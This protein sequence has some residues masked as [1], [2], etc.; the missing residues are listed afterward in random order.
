MSIQFSA[1]RFRE[2]RSVNLAVPVLALALLTLFGTA[3]EKTLASMVSDVSP[4]VVQ[5]VTPFRTGS[6]FIVDE[7]GLVITNAHVVQRFETVDVRLASGQQ[8]HAEVLR[9]DEI[10]DLAL[11]DLRA[12]RDFR[13]VPLGDS[14][15]VMVGEDVIAIGFPSGNTEVLHDSPTITKGI[16]S[17]KRVSGS[18][19]RLLQTDAAINPGTSGGPLFDHE[20]RVV[21]VN[22]L[23]IFESGDGRPVE[24]IGLVVAISEVKDRMGSLEKASLSD[25]FISVSAGQFHTCGLKTDRSVVCWG[26][27]PSSPVGTFDS[28]ST[29]TGGN[30]YSCGVTTDGSVMCWGT[31]ESEFTLSVGSYTSVS[32]GGEHECGVKTD[33]SVE[34]WGT[35]DHGQSTP[36]AGSFTS[37]SAGYQSTCGVKTDS[38]IVC[39]GSNDD[40]RSTPPSGSFAS[41][42]AGWGH[43]C[44]VKTDRSV[45]CWGS[46]DHGESTPPSGSFVSVSAGGDHTCG[47]K[48]DRSVVCWGNDFMGQSSADSRLTLLTSMITGRYNDHRTQATVPGPFASVSAGFWYTCAVKT[49]GAVIC[50][51]DNSAGQ[52]TPPTVRVNM[53]DLALLAVVSA[54]SFCAVALLLTDVEL[55]GAKR[56][57]W[58]V[59]PLTPIICVSVW[60]SNTFFPVAVVLTGA[61]LAI[62]LMGWRLF[63]MKPHLTIR[64]VLGIFLASL[65]IAATLATWGTFSD[66]AID[67]GRGAFY[68]WGTLAG[69]SALATVIVPL[70]RPGLRRAL[71]ATVAFVLMFVFFEVIFLL[72]V[73]NVFSYGGA[74]L[75][76]FVLVAVGAV[77]TATYFGRTGRQLRSDDGTS[78]SGPVSECRTDS[79]PG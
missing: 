32:A 60:T 58:G 64:R 6:G 31:I 49:D 41:V 5:I 76:T 16:V 29:A 9:V 52:A 21:G 70:T 59:I 57:A 13:A 7:D 10:A 48:T 62:M 53:V 11:L 22:T 67:W 35:D 30:S 63:D 73:H 33:G 38:S 79:T 36:P 24:G 66:P 40:S 72:L 68:G 46:N 71:I 65:S 78:D 12:S 54:L 8:Y 3:C 20:G 51:G 55:F 47:V 26:S 56:I 28:I 44:G 19:V 45:V 1:E 18:G 50:W 27:G 37:V 4:G 42:S 74:K 39:W 69:A 77:I 34:C 17:A 15:T 25:S 2:G 61:M 75:A 43:T 14:D 23:K